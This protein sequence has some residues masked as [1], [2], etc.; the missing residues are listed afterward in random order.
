LALHISLLHFRELAE[1][2]RMGR[3]YKATVAT[4]R[5]TSQEGGEAALKLALLRD[6]TTPDGK[7]QVGIC[8]LATGGRIEYTFESSETVFLVS[9]HVTVELGGGE[10]VDLREGDL[11]SFYK[12]D[13][14]TWIVHLRTLGVFALSG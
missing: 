12:G 10:T 4:A 2:R 5:L 11:A 6:E 7:I 3:I 14:S 13:T 1:R 9:G 8:E